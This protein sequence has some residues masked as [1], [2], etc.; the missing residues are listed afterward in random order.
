MGRLVGIEHFLSQIGLDEERADMASLRRAKA[1]LGDDYNPLDPEMTVDDP[2]RE[3]QAL[4]SMRIQG[5]FEQRVL[6]RT[7]ESKN[8]LD[9]RLINLPELHEHIVL[10]TL[11]PWEREIHL[12]LAERMR[13]E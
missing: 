8:W 13:E 11:Q 2:I 1:S 9:E 6:R 7:A 12:Q 4:V 5:Q 3:A 10:L